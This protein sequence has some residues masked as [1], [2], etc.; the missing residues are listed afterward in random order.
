MNKNNELIKKLLNELLIDKN[1]IG[2]SKEINNLDNIFSNLNFKSEDLNFIKAYNLKSCS[3]NKIEKILDQFC[4]IRNLDINDLMFFISALTVIDVYN[5]CYFLQFE[6]NRNLISLNKILSNKNGYILKFSK[7]LINT[8]GDDEFTKLFNIKDRDVLVNFISDLL[9]IRHSFL[10]NYFEYFFD[11][12]W[13]I[14]LKLDI[15]KIFWKLK[16]INADVR[17]E[18]KKIK[19]LKEPLNKNIIENSSFND[20]IWIYKFNL[21]KKETNVSKKIF[22]EKINKRIDFNVRI[23]NYLNNC[24]FK[25]NNNLLK[26]V[27]NLKEKLKKD[28][29]FMSMLALDEANYVKN[30]EWFKFDY[31]MDNR[32][33]LYIKNI[34][35]NC[36]LE[37]IL[38][39]IIINKTVE[40]DVILK[41]YRNFSINFN[42]DIK[43]IFYVTNLK[44]E[45]RLKLIFFIEKELPKKKININNLMLD[46]DI[47]I[48]LIF[49]QQVYDILKRLKIEDL[50]N[51][52]NEILNKI[53]KEED[54]D[55]L[56]FFIELSNWLNNENKWIECMWYNDASSNVLQILLMKLFVNEEIIL[57]VCNIFDNNTEYLDI[58][59]Y[60]LK[61][62]MKDEKLSLFISRKLIKQIIMPGL[63]GQTFISLKNQF[64]ELLKNNF[65]WNELK[66]IGK[67]ILI[68]KIEK[69]VWKE[70]KN[71][72]I[73]IADYLIVLKRLPYETDE[74]Y[75]ENMVGMPI[76]LDKEKSIN[77]GDIL[78]KIKYKNI[79]ERKKLKDKLNKDDSNYLR[80]NIKIDNKKYIK[81]RYRLKSNI[82]DKKSLSNALTPSTTH[83]DD[84]GILFKS[85]ELCM[86]YD[87]ECVPIH[88]SIGSM[89]YYS[90]LIKSI[91]KISNMSFID[92]LLEKDSF[93]F[94]ILSKIKFKKKEIEF[95]KEKLLSKRN[96]NR[97]YYFKNKELIK[98]KILNSEKFFN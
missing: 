87:L 48:D 34:P 93:P 38:R 10:S 59:D 2:F 43:D 75:W 50:S 56:G 80:K 41:K 74:L 60:V 16:Y 95:K 66:D 64:E 11:N 61:N 13:K 30:F 78:K 14:N 52:K 24:K 46:K 96:N 79:E 49:L 25:I 12:N 98:K 22:L 72:G 35:L 18:G 45:D 17:Y 89:V 26:E 63:Y 94:D 71:L 5:N 21:I 15:L 69:K 83:S 44:I 86:A 36:Q 68:K 19:L 51:I 27:L 47:N 88:D 81:L 31:L 58:Y 32:T 29:K 23:I 82:I 1:L 97:D 84:A 37:K 8:L 9:I 28:G 6:I 40:D 90:S 42:I 4:K 20:D 67:N 91:F 53:K 65:N 33:R 55:D 54:L 92:F 73:D 62:L 3:Y 77:R 76:V 70:L 7:L 39:P 85:L 57:K